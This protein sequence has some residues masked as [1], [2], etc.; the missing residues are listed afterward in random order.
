M[1]PANKPRR[2]LVLGCGGVAGAAWSIAALHNLQQL[3]GWDP[4]EAQVIVGTSAGAVLAAM[5]GAGVSVAQ[6]LACQ[7]GQADCGWNHHKDTGPALPPLPALRLTAAGLLARGLRGE[8]HGLTALCGV[9][10]RGR[11]DMTPFRRLIDQLPQPD[12]WVKHP[13]TWL[14]TVD[15]QSGQ[16][17]AFGQSQAPRASLADAVCASY[18]VPGWCPPVAIQG[19]EYLDGGIASPTSADLLLEQPVDEVIILAPMTSQA[20]DRP[21]SPI[22]RIE[23]G[24][25]R[26]MTRILDNEVSALAATGKRV[27]RLSPDAEDLQAIG[28]NM[29]DPKRR[30]TVLTTALRTTEASVRKLQPGL[31]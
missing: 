7:Q 5:L 2:A 29:M 12:G 21:W 28:Y 25:R 18:G 14:V 16:R 8:V 4:R 11:F 19:R 27:I 1:S 6:L 15:S 23:R 3:S 20:P 26:Y 22:T 13:A 10:P 24:A 9:A 30:Q 17:V 31:R